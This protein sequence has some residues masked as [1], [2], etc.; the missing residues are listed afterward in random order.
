MT[1]YPAFSSKTMPRTGVKQSKKIDL[2]LSQ[3]KKHTLL[4]GFSLKKSHLC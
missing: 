1:Q 4:L 3:C 2:L